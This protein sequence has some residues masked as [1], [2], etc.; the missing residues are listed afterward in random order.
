MSDINAELVKRGARPLLVL[1][2]VQD[3]KGIMLN[4]FLTDEYDASDSQ[5]KKDVTAAVEQ[6]YQQMKG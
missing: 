4:F 2:G 1:Y 3:D 6:I 5:L